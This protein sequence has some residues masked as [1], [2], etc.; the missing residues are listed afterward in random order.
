MS[1]ILKSITEV[2]P[3]YR[4]LNREENLNFFRDVLGFKV[5]MEEGAMVWLGG[6]EAKKAHL[7]LEESPG[8]RSANGAKKHGLTVIKAN[9]EE[10][11]QLLAGQLEKI[12]K[13]YQTETGYAFEAISPENDVF[14]LTD[15]E[16]SHL[17][18]IA[19]SAINFSVR[20]NFTGLS[21]FEV[22]EIKVNVTNS[23]TKDFLTEILDEKLTVASTKILFTTS[24]DEDLNVASDET[25]D[26]E[27][28][29]FGVEKEFD[30][31]A[32]E[33]NFDKTV[34]NYLDKSA[35]TLVLT[36][37]NGMEIWFVK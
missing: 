3:V 34:K 22:E 23:A 26:L 19:K 7:L 28:L 20:Q 16:N 31:S 6:H 2:M 9:R 24:D 27:F 25:L 17:T 18:E 4:V 5:L 10:I 32:F 35:R 8:L 30:L 33:E 1:E 12:S 21:N 13:V 15:N 37:P 14:V 11:I 29:R 36:A